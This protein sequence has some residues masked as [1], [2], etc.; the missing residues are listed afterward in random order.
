MVLR[1]SRYL[2]IFIS[3]VSVSILY[4]LAYRWL[5]GVI[6][7]E[8]IVHHFYILAT[9]LLFQSFLAN[10][11]LKIV[12]I[13]QTNKPNKDVITKIFS[14]AVYCSIL[15]FIIINIYNIILH[16]NL[17]FLSY[18]FYFSTI[19]YTQFLRGY[20]EGINNYWLA[21]YV[22]TIPYISFLT[23]PLFIQINLT[24][25]SSLICFI[26]IILQSYKY[27]YKYKLCEFKYDI[28]IEKNTVNAFSNQGHNYLERY[29]VHNMG[30]SGLINS[31]IMDTVGRV[32]TLYNLLYSGCS[33]YLYQA[34]ENNSA[35][36]TTFVFIVF[37]SFLILKNL[38]IYYSADV[39]IF[40]K[41]QDNINP[42]VLFLYL[43]TFYYMSIRVLLLRLLIL[44]GNI[45]L[46]NKLNLVCISIFTILYVASSGYSNWINIGLTFLFR[47]IILTIINIYTLELN[48]RLKFSLIVF[49]TISS[50]ILL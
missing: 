34:Y 24:E 30:E 42:Q 8:S 19:F 31:F 13:L 11:Y 32:V 37:L 21:N 4:V 25:L 44:K 22:R 45:T 36:I 29:N 47:E 28:I 10:D 14:K 15:I 5:N 46:T 26:L 18:S 17:C 39:F 23:T 6:T 33:K 40:L 27:F 35:K 9:G 43:C 38:L 41:F 48:S 12:G 50:F 2:P 20:Y 3:F 16:R 49:I 7:K 1:N